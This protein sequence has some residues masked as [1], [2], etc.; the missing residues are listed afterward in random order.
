[1]HSGVPGI[2]LLLYKLCLRI[3]LPALFQER[4]PKCCLKLVKPRPFHRQCLATLVNFPQVS[5]PW[6]YSL[7]LH[8][9]ALSLVCSSTAPTSQSLAGSAELLLPWDITFKYLAVNSHF[10]IIT[11]FNQK[12][13]FL[14]H[15]PERP[16]PRAGPPHSQGRQP[17]SAGVINSS[18]SFHLCVLGL[19]CFEIRG[20][21]WDSMTPT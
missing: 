5:A 9:P 12:S 4:L 17:S 1:M 2:F 6:N 18:P 20:L 16:L 21:F 8:C 7:G 19:S 15:H 10:W 11:L 3:S 14:S 13:P